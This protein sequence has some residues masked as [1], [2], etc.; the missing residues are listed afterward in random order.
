MDRVRRVSL[1]GLVA[2]AVA[3]VLLVAWAAATTS[4]TELVS[5]GA[6]GGNGAFAAFF[7]DASAD[8]TTL[9]F[10]TEEPLVAEDTDTAR[11]LYQRAG[12]VTTL[13]SIGPDG[14]NDDNFDVESGEISAD[15]SRVFFKT[16]EQLD[17]T[18]DTDDRGDV[19][20]H[21]GAV[22]ALVSTGPNGGNGA[23][24]VDL[25]GFSDDGSRVF[26]R[27]EEAL[28]ADDMDVFP[29]LYE[30]SGGT[31]TLISTGPKGY[32]GTFP[33]DFQLNSEDGT[34]VFIYTAEQFVNEDTDD[35]GDSY[36]RSGGTTT[37]LVPTDGAFSNGV[38][39]TSAD[40]TRA[41]LQ[42]QEP[43]AMG[44]TD[45]SF[46]V[47]EWRNGTRTL[48]STG[49]AGGNGPV[50]SIY[51]D[52]SRDG[53]KVF[54]ATL[55]PLVA[56][57]TDGGRM[58]IYQRS[59]S[60]TTLVSAGGNGSFDASY[61][62]ASDDGSH[63]LFRTAEQLVATDTDSQEDL[64]ERADGVTSLVSTG[65]A[66]GN[67]AFDADSDG[68]S[69]DGRR[70]LFQTE[71]ALTGADTDSRLDI[72]ERS[73]GE[74]TLL[75]TGSGGGN[76]AFD[77][78]FQG[79]SASGTRLFFDTGEPL[80]AGDIDAQLDQYMATISPVKVVTPPS[81]PSPPSRPPPLVTDTTAPQTGFT[82]RPRN[83]TRRRS[84]VFRFGSSEAGSSFECKLDRRP[85]RSCR[86][87]KHVKVR[88]GKHAF[89]VRA[90]DVAGNADT[91]PAVDRWTVLKK[92]RK[93]RRG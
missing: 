10:A 31:T 42:T 23:F 38:E 74:T 76:G 1:A 51:Q 66:G 79:A 4:S 75:S 70:V 48:L 58:D 17:A 69:A 40:G 72:Y 86:S 56:G 71:E 15:G 47:F 11:D 7:Q 93:R 2:L 14:G 92:K 22:T 19:Y 62:D 26:I 30:R 12:G 57:D 82:K 37:L 78:G 84:S 9:L 35:R 89:R 91:S 60:T 67:G 28:V 77:A 73:D 34:R 52:A 83:R 16:E 59:G 33:S 88:P 50:D 54:F 25:K 85:F 3:A 20:E 13:V 36:L 6:T 65:P 90:I 64:Y 68:I 80:T 45:N 24:D 29:D 44:D 21:S 61:Q 87:P 27:T 18:A 41:F 81:G 49:P 5:T 53:T 55:E 43:V 46:D 63:V 8:G 32:N 39:G